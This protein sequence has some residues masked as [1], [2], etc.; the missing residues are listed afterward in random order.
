MGDLCMRRS[1][2]RQGSRVGVGALLAAQSGTPVTE[3]RNCRPTEANG[4][5]VPKGTEWTCPCGKRW[6]K[7][8]YGGWERISDEG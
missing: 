2:A 6:R 1:V 4:Y 5:G 8:N 7:G 3:H